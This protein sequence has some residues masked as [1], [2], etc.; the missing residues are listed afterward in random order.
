[1]AICVAV[2]GTALRVVGE[3]TADCAGYALMSAQ[4]YASVP[5]LATLFALPDPDSVQAAFMAGLSLP[6]IL[7]LTSWGLGAIVNFINSRSVTQTLDE[8]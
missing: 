2:D 3:Y 5:T 4:E 8:D 7:W 6:V 1:M